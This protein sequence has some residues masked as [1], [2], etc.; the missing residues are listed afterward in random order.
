MGHGIAQSFM[1]NVYTVMLHD[2]HDS[3]LET[4][5]AHI[6]N[7]LELFRQAELIADADIENAMKRLTLTA[8]LEKAAK[9]A[10]FIVEAIPEDL[11]LKQDLFCLVTEG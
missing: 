5:K 1:M 2:L 9:P 6:K 7:N 11:S 3:I 8:D 10:D 4:A